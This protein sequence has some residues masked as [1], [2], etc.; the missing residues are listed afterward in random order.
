MDAMV[1]R[2]FLQI[3][4]TPREFSLISEVQVQ[5]QGFSASSSLYYITRSKYFQY[6]K[7]WL[8]Y[9]FILLPLFHSFDFFISS[10]TT[11]HIHFSSKYLIYFDLLY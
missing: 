10:L 8:H 4:V 9:T 11:H 7:F 3:S 5:E 1:T 6:G 2:K